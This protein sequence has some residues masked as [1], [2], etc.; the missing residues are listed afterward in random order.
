MTGRYVPPIVAITHF[1]FPL[2]LAV[3][4]GGTPTT[5]ALVVM[6]RFHV[7]IM[8]CFPMGVPMEWNVL[9]LYS[10]LVLFGANADVSL[11][12]V[13]GNPLLAAIQAAAGSRR[14]SCDASSSNPGR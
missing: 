8:S 1:L 2:I 10:M 5:I 3:S 12:A 7:F 9:F 6:L 13:F 14:A 11:L 4:T